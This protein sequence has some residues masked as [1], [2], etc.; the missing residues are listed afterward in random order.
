MIGAFLQYLKLAFRYLDLEILNSTADIGTFKA[1]Q[2]L[3]M[4]AC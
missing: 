2:V 1:T 3:G 4:L